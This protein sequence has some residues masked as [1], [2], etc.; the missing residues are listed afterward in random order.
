MFGHPLGLYI[1]FFTEMWERFS[2]YGMRAILV[3]YLVAQTESGGLGWTNQEALSLYGWYTMFVYLMSIPGGMIADKILGQKKSVMLGGLLLV[4]GHSLMAYTAPWAFYTALCLIVLGVGLL[5]PNISTMVGGLYD[6]KDDRRDAGFTIF[7]IGINLGAFLASLIVG[8]VGERI[9]WHYGFALAGIGMA[10]GQ[11][12]F[13]WGQ[14]HLKD[15]GN[16][17]RYNLKVGESHRPPLT[18]VE[19]DRIRVLLIS[20]L[21]VI[22]FWAAYEQ[23]GGFL[24]LYADQLTNRILLGWEIPASWFQALNPI[25]IIGF[26]GVVA[27]IWTVLAKRHREPSAI[28]KMGLGTVIMGLGFV[29]MIGAAVQ[30]IQEPSGLS[31]LWWLVGAYW[32]HTIGELALSPVALAYITKLSPKHLVAS[33][34]GVYFAATG[35]ANKLAAELGAMSE[36]LGDLGVFVLIASLSIGLGSLLM[37]YT[38]RINRLAHED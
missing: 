29:L 10:L 9:G 32:F 33:M 27:W 23:G 22:V 1:L 4:V 20:F 13:I 3:L 16:L 34:M 21:I 5:K 24:N 7:Y 28:F 38:R 14:K 15:V 18:L 35:L 17:D 12:V 26:G 36:K 11:A 2:Y 8:Y 31:S 19:K 37:F 6:H 30:R 25:F